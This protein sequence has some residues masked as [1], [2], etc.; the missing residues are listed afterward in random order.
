MRTDLAVVLAEEFGMTMSAA[1]I[2]AWVCLLTFVA[3]KYDR[4][5]WFLLAYLTLV[6]SWIMVKI[7]TLGAFEGGPSRLL[8]FLGRQLLVRANVGDIV[9]G[10]STPYEAYYLHPHLNTC[11]LA[12]C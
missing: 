5:A 7:S 10:S 3:I 2:G 4:V 11:S 12:W 6:A 8:G 9:V 1:T